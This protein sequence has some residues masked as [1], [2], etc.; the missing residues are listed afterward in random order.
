MLRCGC[1][2]DKATTTGA[3]AHARTLGRCS[4]APSAFHS[5]P[6]PGHPKSPTVSVV[7]VLPH[8]CALLWIPCRRL[9]HPTRSDSRIEAARMIVSLGLLDKGPLHS[10]N[11]SPVGAGAAGPPAAPPLTPP[12]PAAAPSA[13]AVTR[14]PPDN[15]PDTAGSLWAATTRTTCPNSAASSR[16]SSGDS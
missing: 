9:Q 5:V 4:P 14:S 3:P 16:S 8:L 11:I 13:S 10:K 1:W 6:P 15:P 7:L 12:P 2:C